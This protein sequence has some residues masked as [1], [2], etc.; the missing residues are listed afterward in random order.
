MSTNQ[1][2]QKPD[3]VNR[4]LAPLFAALIGSSPA[5]YISFEM[6]SDLSKQTAIN[7]NE[8]LARGRWMQRFEVLSDGQNQ[9]LADTARKVERI[10]AMQ[11]QMHRLKN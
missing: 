7:Q 2:V 10:E 11:E 6:F 5:T 1:P 3:N 4:V 8:L 9:L